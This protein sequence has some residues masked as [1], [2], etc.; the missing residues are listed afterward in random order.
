MLG[1][2]RATAIL[3]EY[4]GAGNVIAV[5]FRVDTI[6]GPMSF[7]LPCNPQAISTI[8]NKQVQAK[9]IPKR[10][11]NDMDQARRVGWRIIKDWLEAQMAIVATE[12]VT[13]DQ[14]FLPYAQMKNGDTVYEML[15]R[16]GY[17]GLLLEDK[18]SKR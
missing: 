12:M 11:H 8:L 5:S 14:V 13:L 9:V 10:F 6:M 3:S 16:K 2:A 15:Q 17:D 18:V 4:D 7:R 1:K